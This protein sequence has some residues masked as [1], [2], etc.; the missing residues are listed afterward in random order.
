MGHFIEISNMNFLRAYTLDD[1]FNKII[2]IAI[3]KI[4]LYRDLV[5]A[6]VNKLILHASSHD[7]YFVVGLVSDFSQ[8]TSQQLKTC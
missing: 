5:H 6:Q 4:L 7:P 1:N 8:S 3:P 2:S